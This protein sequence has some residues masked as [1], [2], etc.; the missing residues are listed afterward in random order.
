LAAGR[1]DEAVAVF[2]LNVEAYP[3]SPNVYDSLGD[4]H[5][6]RGDL[7]AAIAAYRKA[8]EVDPNFGPSR[9]NLVEL[10]GQ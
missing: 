1:L 5:R 9:A 6:A 3:D 10:L 2:E 8:L 4:G 7:E